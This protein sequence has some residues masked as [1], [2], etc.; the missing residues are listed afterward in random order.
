MSE[1]TEP[2]HGK[3]LTKLGKSDKETGM[4]LVS[5]ITRTEGGAAPD[6]W[7]KKMKMLDPARIRRLDR[8]NGLDMAA[9]HQTAGGYVAGRKKGGCGGG[10][11]QK[12]NVVSANRKPKGEDC[13]AEETEKPIGK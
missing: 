11:Y 3:V 1:E 6:N 7:D 13:R 4:R 2:S 9:H 8:R 5:E 12:R 10:D